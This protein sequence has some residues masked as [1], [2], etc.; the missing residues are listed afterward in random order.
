MTQALKDKRILVTGAAGGIGKAIVQ[1]LAGEGA[2]LVMHYF[3]EEEEAQ[4]LLEEINRVNGKAHI[5][6]ADLSKREEAIA[7]GEKAWALLG[8]IDVLVNNAGVSYKQHFLDTTPED[9]DH[10]LDINFKGTL[11][12]TKTIA[13]K[14]VKAGLPGSIYSITSINGIQP[15][16]GFSV[17]GASKAALETLMKGVALELAPHQITVN[18]IAPGAIETGLN[19]GIWQDEEKLKTVNENIPMGRFGKPEEIAA[20]VCSLIASNSYMT[21]VTIT[22]DGGWLLKHGFAKPERYKDNS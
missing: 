5:V 19:A 14:M 3:N 13:A 12:L 7:L 10:F 18:T 1:Q 15:G 6:K 9:L 22:I 21:G 11:W 4:Q 17:Y 16:W 20:V 2:A 8:G